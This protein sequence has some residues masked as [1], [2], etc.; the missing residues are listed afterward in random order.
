LGTYVTIAACPVGY[1]G[2][3]RAIDRR[4][5]MTEEQATER[6]EQ[7]EQQEQE[8]QEEERQG[9]DAEGSS[10]G[11]DAAS[12]AQEVEEDYE[13]AK[14]E[15]REL[16]EDPP[17][18]LEDWPE[19][20]AKYETFGGPEGEHGY[21]EGPEQK[22]GPSALRHREDGAVEVEGEE[23]DDSSE[24]KGPPIPGGPTDPDTPNLRMDKASPED[25]SDVA[26]EAQSESE[27]EGESSSEG[28]SSDDDGDGQSGEE[29]GGES[30]GEAS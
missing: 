3:E 22:L 5:R 24:Y 14:Q 29:S 26:Q 13:E 6:E 27:E 21:H 23:V 9:S 2:S 30:S 7:Q 15:V 4:D 25:V 11:E 1:S 19:G 20:K 28:E 8:E 16:E 12:K 17:A 10:E 18:K